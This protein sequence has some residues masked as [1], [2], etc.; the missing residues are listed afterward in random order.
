MV[1]LETK[2]TKREPGIGATAHRDWLRAL[3]AT[4]P[5][6][7][8]PNR[9]LF[10]IIA[11]VA[12]TSPDA[13]ALIGSD[14]SLT[15]AQLAAR[16]NS[17][18]RWAIAQGIAKGET[19]CLMMPNRPEYMAI[20]LGLST[21]GVVV[22]LINT[23]LRGPSLAHCIDA[24]TPKHLIA[25]AAL[26]EDLQSLAP[27]LQTRP[28][29]WVHGGDGAFERIDH[30]VAR[31]PGEALNLW[32]R[33][34]V[35]IADR[36]LLIY[37]SGTTGLPK[38]A[39]VS[40][41]RVLRWS[42]WFAGLMNTGPLDRVYNCL[43]MNHSVGGIVA[44]GAALVRGGSVLIRD[45]FS[46]HQ[47]WDDI[48]DGD[49]TLFQYIGEL[50]RYLVNAPS[51]PR[52]RTHRLRLACGNGLRGDIWEKF[53]TR[54]AIPRILEFYASTEG[55]FSLYNVEGKIGAVGR[56]PPFLHHSFPLALVKFDDASSL[57][58]RDEDGH[59]RRCATG[60][61]GEA[62]GRIHDASARISS[63][64]EGYSKAEQSEQKVLRD[65]FERGD[66]WYRTGDLMRVDESGF[67]YFVDRIGD[68]FRWK[69]ENVSTSEVAAAIGAF[70]GV[71]EANVYGV[72]VPGTDGAA[73]MAA[74]ICD[75]NPDLAALRE[76]L[77]AWL[78]PYARPLFL[79]LPDR[80]EATATFK[81]TKTSLQ[82]EG[83]D[84]AATSDA[85][86]FDDPVKKAFV[87]LDA[88]LFA[89]IAAGKVRL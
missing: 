60:E 8:E 52:E 33:R 69:G 14:Q 46:A 49:C 39:N 50:A 22:A 68:T 42:L 29:I 85:I 88:A 45:K 61:T 27:S 77:A 71:K 36:A 30:V 73:G 5:I 26:S 15:Y 63:E 79:R 35:T 74:I 40:H 10:D 1:L 13:P 48:T 3:E 41:R 57:P 44:T 83:F 51:H 43:P 67:Y 56:V 53:R 11:G 89:R 20:W 59:C 37:T 47:F 84:P 16:A 18:A 28:T 6:A 70:P 25:A 9:L 32:E 38:A 80:L 76:H 82:R 58:M 12:K 64:F 24:V 55:N 62:I 2:R 75:G 54:F 72:R 21:V 65:V 31:L 66:A 23:Q 78:P 87:P 17:Y 81:H 34:P 4:A 19:V 7:K 86:Y